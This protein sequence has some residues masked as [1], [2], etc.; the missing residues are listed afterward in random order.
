MA[1]LLMLSGLPASGKSTRAKEIVATGN[2]VRVNRD[3]LR[4]ML[5]NDKF[6]GRNEGLTVDAEK[7]IAMQALSKGLNVV[8]D[9]TNLNPKNRFM[10]NDVATSCGATFEYEK[11]DTDWIECA[12]RDSGRTNP[13]GS[14]VIKNMA[15]QYGMATFNRDSIVLCDIDGTLADTT[16]R[17]HYLEGGKKDW[18]GF[19]S[20]MSKDPIR[21]EVR[22]KL[23]DLYNKGKGVIYVSARPEDY[24]DVTLKWLEKNG[25]SFAFTILM[26]RSNDSRPDT[27]VKKQ[28]LD[29]YFPDKSVIHKVIDDRPSVIRMWRENGLEVD[30]VGN[31][32][33]F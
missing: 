30:D 7:I 3:L 24:R 33:E 31:G 2:W 25:V 17:L 28:I 26:R 18:R 20:E 1:K 11:I 27:E 13:V 19:F 16:H 12:V 23:I 5:H 15:I 14:T 29:T 22:S 8:V 21:N 32:K 4:T 10:W 9:D 6:T